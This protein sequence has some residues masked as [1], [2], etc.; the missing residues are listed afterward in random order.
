MRAALLLLCISL[1]IPTRAQEIEA[2]AA[3]VA[4]SCDDALMYETADAHPEIR[5]VSPRPGAPG[6]RALGCLLTQD[7]D[8]GTLETKAYMSSGLYQFIR[9]CRQEDGDIYRVFEYK[10]KQKPYLLRLHR[11]PMVDPKTYIVVLS[12]R[13]PSGN[14]SHM[15]V[16]RANAALKIKR[17][18]ADS[19]MSK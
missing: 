12:S 13:R 15:V 4:N 3:V 2:P 18:P 1:V 19:A 17:C 16:E 10:K 11:D 14:F 5:W 8:N 7:A 6:D 9:E